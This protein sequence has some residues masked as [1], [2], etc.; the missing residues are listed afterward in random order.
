M[1]GAV[2]EIVTHLEMT[3]SAHLRPAP[4]VR[5]VSVA[6]VPADSPLV[7]PTTVRIGKPYDWPSTR[8]ND[9]DWAAYLAREGRE[10]LI[11]SH[12]G[13]DAGLADYQCHGAGEVEITTFGLVP[14]YVGKGI[15]GYALTLVVEHAWTLG[16]GVRRVWLHTSDLDHPHALPNYHRRGFRTFRTARGQR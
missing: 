15:G 14:E 4:V 8:W 9:E 7:R 3:S 11:I 16:P 13:E 12:L 6:R 5:E 10:C 1:L 2:E